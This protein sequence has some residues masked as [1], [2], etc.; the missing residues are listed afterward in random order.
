MATGNYLDPEWERESKLDSYYS[1]EDES[2]SLF[3]KKTIQFNCNLI[4]TQ[5]SHQKNY[6]YQ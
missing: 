6:L 5:I 2:I 4:H 3:P 1:E